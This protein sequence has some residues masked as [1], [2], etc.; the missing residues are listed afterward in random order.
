M[1]FGDAYKKL[2]D[3][4]TVFNPE[5]KMQFDSTQVYT[6]ALT[7]NNYRVKQQRGTIISEELNCTY[8][9]SPTQF[10][11]AGSAGYNIKE[12]E[13]NL[14]QAV[15]TIRKIPWMQMIT[16]ASKSII[17]TTVASEQQNLLNALRSVVAASDNTIRLTLILNPA[18]IPVGTAGSRLQ[19]LTA[20][21]K[22][23]MSKIEDAVNLIQQITTKIQFLPGQT[24]AVEIDAVLDELAEYY[25]AKEYVDAFEA[26]FTYLQSVLEDPTYAKSS[27]SN[28]QK[29]EI[30]Q[31]ILNFKTFMGTIASY[32]DLS[33]DT[34]YVIDHLLAESGLPGKS[35]IESLLEFVKAKDTVDSL[36]AQINMRLNKTNDERVKFLHAL[37]S[38]ILQLMKINQL[39]KS[40]GLNDKFNVIVGILFDDMLNALTRIDYSLDKTIVNETKEY[41]NVLKAL[42]KYSLN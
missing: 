19:R 40:K 36:Q 34:L 27:A 30:A 16:Q 23:E 37:N 28:A 33:T 20:R 5:V 2:Q 3:F 22:I 21:N 13:I 12:L 26:Y 42:I 25:E 14:G 32:I 1:W 17:P 39:I 29:A 8:S 24:Q 31:E 11:P 15:S 35:N 4:F 7:I 6:F 18:G 9:G 10:I 41:S 38:A